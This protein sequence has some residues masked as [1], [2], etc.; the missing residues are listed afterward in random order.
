LI[1]RFRGVR[2]INPLKLQIQ[3]ELTDL[4]I[5]AQS[6]CGFSYCFHYNCFMVYCLSLT[7][8]HMPGRLRWASP[9]TLQCFMFLHLKR[10][11]HSPLD[12]FFSSLIE[13]RT[14]GKNIYDHYTSPFLLMVMGSGFQRLKRLTNLASFRLLRGGWES[15]GFGYIPEPGGGGEI[16]DRATICQR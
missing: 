9:R 15:E 4:T 5:Q 1:V 13:S 7:D 16:R 11:C 6:L 2:I 8:H 14:K 12:A 10:L 3:N